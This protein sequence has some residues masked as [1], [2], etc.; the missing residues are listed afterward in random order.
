MNRTE[1]KKKKCH[2]QK[3]KDCMRMW[4]NTSR[5]GLFEVVIGKRVLR[6]MKKMGAVKGLVCR[7]VA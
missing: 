5:G 7:F 3:R 4:G 1:K 6:A 2:F